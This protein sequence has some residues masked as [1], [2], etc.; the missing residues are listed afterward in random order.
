MR[1][2]ETCGS[3]LHQ[4]QLTYQP[5]VLQAFISNEVQL[6]KCKRACGEAL[7]VTCVIFITD[8]ALHSLSVQSYGARK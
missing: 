5:E 7:L 6:V 2:Q 8:S 1:V 4:S 3:H